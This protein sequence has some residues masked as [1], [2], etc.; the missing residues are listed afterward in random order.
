MRQRIADSKRGMKA[1]LRE[2]SSSHTSVASLALLV[3]GLAAFRGCVGH[4]EAG[5]GAIERERLEP[6]IVMIEDGDP[7]SPWECVMESPPAISRGAADSSG[8]G[9]PEITLTRVPSY[10]VSRSIESVV[11]EL[12]GFGTVLGLALTSPVAEE[13]GRYLSLVL[14]S[15]SGPEDLEFE[16]ALM[17]HFMHHDPDLGMRRGAY[18]FLSQLPMPLA[19]ERATLESFLARGDGEDRAWTATS[20]YYSLMNLSNSLPADDGTEAAS[21]SRDRIR[22]LRPLLEATLQD[23]DPFV[24]RRGRDYFEKYP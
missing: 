21:H 2:F 18:A 7:A 22:M 8:G 3:L 19:E 17:R 4:R 13:R 9:E 14:E 23:P 10:E 6:C 5:A 24:A 20:I 11:D 12:G 15:L 16:L 1:R